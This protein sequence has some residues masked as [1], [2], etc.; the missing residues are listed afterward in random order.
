MRPTGDTSG[1]SKG[2]L[3]ERNGTA[4]KVGNDDEGWSSEEE[5]AVQSGEHVEPTAVA[6]GECDRDREDQRVDEEAPARNV[7][8]PKGPLPEEG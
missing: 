6:G 3:G 4:I 2:I 1:K 7:R 5:M 8:N